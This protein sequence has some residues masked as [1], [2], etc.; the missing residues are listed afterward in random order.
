MATYSGDFSYLTGDN[1]G[2]LTGIAGAGN[3]DTLMILEIG[4]ELEILGGHAGDFLTSDVNPEVLVRILDLTARL[5]LE[6]REGKPVGA[7]FIV[8]DDQKVLS[9]TRQMT[10]NPFRGYP[11]EER[12]ILSPELEETVKEFASIDGV[13]IVRGDGVILT[14]GA[15]LQP[16]GGEKPIEPGLGARHTAAAS[17]TEATS[18]IAVVLSESTGTARLYRDGSVVMA[19]ERPK[20]PV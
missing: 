17:I 18:S 1:I 8:G 13:F 11:E 14:A 15:Y 7:S 9:F 10:I 4:K 6:G 12:N 19:I 2:S 20:G 16:P 3:P 5:S